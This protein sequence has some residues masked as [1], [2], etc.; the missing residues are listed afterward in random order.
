MA[1][2]HTKTMVEKIF[3]FAVVVLLISEF[4]RSPMWRLHC[5][6]EIIESISNHL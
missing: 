3:N 2:L 4:Y 6:R 5:G 1:P